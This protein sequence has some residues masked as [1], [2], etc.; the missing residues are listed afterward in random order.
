MTKTFTQDDVVRY[1]Y[2]E[3]SA[4]EN[5]IIEDALMAE[6]SMMTF[7]LET[8]EMRAML[9]LIER[10]PRRSTVDSILSYSRNFA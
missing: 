2:E 10:K 4:E 9:N 6:T 5:L 1:V 7:F 3:T 8:V